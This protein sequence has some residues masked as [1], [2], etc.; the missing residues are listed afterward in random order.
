MH[1]DVTETV[2]NRVYCSLKLGVLWIC[3]GKPLF[4]KVKLSLSMPWR[5]YVGL[6]MF[7]IMQLYPLCLDLQLTSALSFQLLFQIWSSGIG[8]VLK[9]WQIYEHLCTTNNIPY[10]IWSSHNSVAEDWGLVGRYAMSNGKQLL[11]FRR[12]VVLHLQGQAARRKTPPKCWYPQWYYMVWKT[13][14]I[15]IWTGLYLSPTDIQVW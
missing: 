3:L 4:I 8:Q 5:H 6:E 9:N 7:F 12:T 2:V 1:E 10:E 11:M 14:K 13:R 15:N